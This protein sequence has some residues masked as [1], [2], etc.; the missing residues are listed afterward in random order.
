[1]TKEREALKLA[2]EALKKIAFAGMAAPPEMSEEG[3]TKWHAR[4]AFNFIGIAAWTLDSIKEVLAQPEQEPVAR[5]GMIGE[6]HFAE[7]CRKAGGNSS[8]PLYAAP[9]KRTWVGL[10]WGD[11]PEEWVGDTKF[12]TGAKWAEQILEEKNND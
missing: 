7:V 8:T 5:I 3:R 11:L 9:P 1:M 6:D 12:L 2:L 4:E 10:N